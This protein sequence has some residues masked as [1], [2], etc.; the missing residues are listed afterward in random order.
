M[1]IER[2][3][4]DDEASSINSQTMQE[5]SEFNL[6]TMLKPSIQIDG[7]QWCVLYGEDLQAGIAGFGDSPHMAIMDFN[8]AWYKS[9]EQ[10]SETTNPEIFSGTRDSLNKLTLR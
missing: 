5:Q 7:N 4:H 2:N 1:N 10:K 9:I 3:Y 6:F 8:S